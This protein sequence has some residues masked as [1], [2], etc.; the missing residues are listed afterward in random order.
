MAARVVM[1]QGT[2]SSVGKSL[3]VAALYRIFAQLTATKSIWDA[4]GAHSHGL[5]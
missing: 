1:L 4:P 5:P 3:L 2:S